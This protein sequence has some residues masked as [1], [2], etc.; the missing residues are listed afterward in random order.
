ME[1]LQNLEAEYKEQQD[2]L[3]ATIASKRD[4]ISIWTV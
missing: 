4:E 1:N 2:E 3:D